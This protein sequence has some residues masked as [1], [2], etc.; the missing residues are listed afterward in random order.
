[1]ARNWLW[2]INRRLRKTGFEIQR[3]PKSRSALELLETMSNMTEGMQG[4]QQLQDFA[5]YLRG[6]TLLFDKNVTPLSQLGQECWILGQMG[7]K[8][9]TFLEI[10]AFHPVQWSNSNLLRNY[11]GWSGFH[12]DPSAQSQSNFE[13][14][15]LKDFFLPYAIGSRRG[16]AYLVGDGAF[17]QVFPSAFEAE[18]KSATSEHKADRAIKI[19]RTITPR[20]V[21]EIV[22]HIDYLSLDIE[23]GES[24]VIELWPFELCSPKFIT[25]EHNHRFEDK[26]K[27][28]KLLQNQG[29]RLTLEPISDF[30]SWFTRI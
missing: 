11:F 10:G 1:M 28:N 29:Y 27:L 8:P 25:V 13:R 15:Q 2:T 23:G 4:S 14:H 24:E 3:Y 7:E 18:N 9:G 19:I 5:D 30:E 17:A 12:V 26:I 22:G 6:F 21:V 16:D 20:D